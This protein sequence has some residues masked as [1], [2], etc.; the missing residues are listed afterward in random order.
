MSNYG[1]AASGAQGDVVCQDD[2][3]VGGTVWAKGG[4]QNSYAEATATADGLTTGLIPRGARFVQVTAGGDAN[5]IITLPAMNADDAGYQ[6]WGR[7][8]ATGCEIRTPA[9]SNVKINNVDADGSNEYALPANCT[10]LALYVGVTPGWIII[11][12]TNLGALA[13]AV[14]PDP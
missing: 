4:V 7:I 13:T 2:L 12:F 6:V 11:H 3:I 1:E 8:G 5:A 14:V 9:A 10:F